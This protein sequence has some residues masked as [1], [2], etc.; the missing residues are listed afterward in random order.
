MNSQARPID[1]LFRSLVFILIGML[2]PNPWIVADEFRVLAHNK[3]FPPYF[4]TKE[5]AQTG[6]YKDFFEAIGELTGDTFR[7]HSH[8]IK[9]G[10]VMFEE[11]QIDIEPGINPLWRVDEKTPGLYSIPYAQSVDI[12]L[13]APGKRI[14]ITKPADLSGKRIGV[15]RGYQY[16]GFSRLFESGAIE[17]YDVTDESLLLGMLPLG[18][19]D[20]VIINKDLALYEMQNNPDYR[21]LELGYEVSRVDVMLRLHPC[22]GT[23]L[24]R[25]N[26]AIKHLID[27]GRVE[28]IWRKYRLFDK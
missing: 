18:R 21:S 13:F 2:M 11:S 14:A 1:L 9:R 10:L 3:A 22:V 20:Q 26:A 17:R 6:F 5:N 23:A 28:Q 7:F 15:V 27:S 4:F 25:L 8:P 19:L 16:P 12:I 24:P